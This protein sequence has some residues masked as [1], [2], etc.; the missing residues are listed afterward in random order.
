M[1][2]HP[3]D[4]SDPLNSPP[5][6]YPSKNMLTGNHYLLSQALCLSL[7][8][9]QLKFQESKGR[10]LP[11]RKKWTRTQNRVKMTIY[12]GTGMGLFLVAVT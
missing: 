9:T 10:L 4:T 5:P 11:S 8:K 7:T 6:S 3:P 12:G 2:W 1:A